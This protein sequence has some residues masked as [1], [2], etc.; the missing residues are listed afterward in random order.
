MC[1]PFFPLS[2]FASCLADS[3]D[4]DFIHVRKIAAVVAGIAVAKKLAFGGCG[5]DDRDE[6]AGVVIESVRVD[7]VVA[8][9]I[10]TTDD[11]SHVNDGGDDAAESEQRAIVRV[12]VE[13]IFGR[14]LARAAEEQNAAD[15]HAANVQTKDAKRSIQDMAA[16]HLSRLAARDL[17]IA[18]LEKELADEKRA[19][20]QQLI[21][22]SETSTLITNLENS[23]KTNKLLEEEKNKQILSLCDYVARLE[24]E[25]TAVRDELAQTVAAAQQD[26]VDKALAL[27]AAARSSADEIQVLKAQA[28]EDKAQL[29]REAAKERA[30]ALAE[31]KC[32]MEASAAK[33]KA[34]AVAQHEEA[35]ARIAELDTK[36]AEMAAAAALNAREM[37]SRALAIAELKET[38]ATAEVRLHDQM[39][40]QAARLEHELA[41][42][43]EDMEALRK[44]SLRQQ[45]EQ[46]EEHQ[47][48]INGMEKQ[49]NEKDA[50]IATLKQQLCDTQGAARSSDDEIQA[51]K[52]QAAEEKTQ[53]E[54]AAAKE[55]ATVLANLKSTMEK[56][57]AK[58][59]TAA[60]SEQKAAL[61][62]LFMSQKTAALNKQRVAMEDDFSGDKSVALAEQ[63]KVLCAHFEEHKEVA[64]MTLQS[65]MENDHSSA[66]RSLERKLKSEFEAEK[67]QTID[68]LQ[69]DLK[70]AA[71]VTLKAQL[72]D[73]RHTLV[74]EHKK[75]MTL[76]V[77]EAKE[78]ERAAQ[79]GEKNTALLQQR[80]QLIHEGHI[81]LQN[82]LEHQ[83]T[84]LTSSLESEHA[85]KLEEQRTTLSVAEEQ[86]LAL[87]L[88]EQKCQLTKEFTSNQIKVTDHLREKLTREMEEKLEAQ[89]RE[90]TDA[91]QDAVQDIRHEMAD[92]VEAAN[93]LITVIDS[94]K[95]RTE[96]STTTTYND[97]VTTEEVLVHAP[98]K[99]VHDS[100]TAQNEAAFESRDVLQHRLKDSFQEMEACENHAESNNFE[101]RTQETTT[102]TMTRIY[103]IEGKQ[104]DDDYGSQKE[105]SS[106][107]TTQKS[108]CPVHTVAQSTEEA[109]VDVIVPT[110][111]KS[112]P[113]RNMKD[114]IAPLRTTRVSHVSKVSV[115]RSTN[116]EARLRS[117]RA[118]PSVA[119]APHW[120]QQPGTSKEKP[121]GS[122]DDNDDDKQQV[123]GSAQ[124]HSGGLASNDT[125][126]PARIRV[127]S[128]RRRLSFADL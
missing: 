5:R 78:S 76:A 80:E 61:E 3:I 123:G 120:P 86:R 124:A 53:L 32:T 75:A 4:M 48:E 42:R 44:S 103:E 50:E 18:S 97:P 1:V 25:V 110:K 71:E 20:E 79:M 66:L 121:H 8:A 109:F 58:K 51:L 115:Q 74:Q 28:A 59:R 23:I 128:A 46:L 67:L 82:E 15:L 127:Q 106:T 45:S 29:D 94:K 84:S 87:A 105:V 26:A 39:A 24:H 91:K 41:L 89:K 116:R 17:H 101:T 60:L 70:S 108:I 65:K 99:A 43:H 85:V 57:A 113:A 35:I 12:N 92:A 107:E 98:V 69:A 125:Q 114:A 33:E 16:A 95:I 122:T 90:L 102:M 6:D 47:L 52:A 126:P 73:L 36:L 27:D 112:V 40:V 118:T 19:H 117:A 111:Y 31:L 55:R 63:R 30:T 13:A 54:R 72:E 34:A 62:K 11:D 96:A 64:L 7:D 119:S 83:R 22:S 77:K 56:N 104:T 93:T 10:D 38:L 100:V 9:S 21:K 68:A 81:T 14:V 49:L 37:N 2:P 88:E